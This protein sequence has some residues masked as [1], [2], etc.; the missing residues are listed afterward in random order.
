MYFLGVKKLKLAKFLNIKGVLLDQNQLQNYLEKVASEHILQAKSNKDTYPI[1]RLDENFKQITKTYDILNSH[2]K[3]GINIHPAGEWLLDNYYIIEETYKT[4]K[5]EL[6]LKKYTNFVGIQNGEYDGF[7]RIYVLA[8]E[9]VGYTDGRIDSDKLK[10]FLNAYQNKKTLGMEEIWNISVFLNISLIEKIRNVCDKVYFVQIQKY[11]VESIIERLVENKQDQDLVY[12]RNINSAKLPFSKEPFIEYLSYRLN[13]YG[14]KGL[15]YLKILEEQVEKTGTTISEIIKK[16]HFDIA[17]KKLSIGNCIK[18]IKDIQRINFTEIFEK[19]NGV[20]EILKKDPANVY[21]KMTYKTKEYYR[22]EIKELSK[23]IGISEIYITSKALELANKNKDDKKKKHIGYYIIDKGLRE[24]KKELDIKE[25]CLNYPKQKEKL[26]IGT[27]IGLTSIFTLLTTTIFINITQNLILYILFLMFSFI[28]ISEIVIKAI[29]YILSKNVKPK[30]IPK[31]D[32]TN[33][34]PKE[35]STMIIMP[36]ILKSKENVQEY[37]EKLEVYYLANK[38]EN[39]YFTLLGDCSTSSKEVEKYD[40]EVIEEGKQI[41]QKLNQKY[42]E[43]IFNF[44]YRKR[45]WNSKENNFL[46]WERKRG[47]ITEF[48]QFLLGKTENTF[49][50]NSL[51]NIELPNIKYIITLDSDTNLVLDTAKELIG[52]MAHILNTPVID[53]KRNIV[54]EGHALMQPRIGIDIDSS[55]KTLFTKIYA[56]MGGIDAYSGAISDIYQDNFG[57]GIFTGKGIYDLQVF[58]KV[59]ENAIPE[60]TVLSHD[61]LEGIYTRCGLVTD[62]ILLDG[63]PTKFNSYITR[64]SRWIRGDW[65][66]ISWLKNVITNKKQNKINNPIGEF[67]KFKILDNLRRSLLEITQLLS[68]IIILFTNDTNSISLYLIIFFSIFIDLVIELLNT[69]IFKKEGVKKQ[70]SFENKLPGL[71][72]SVVRSIINFSSIIYKAIISLK[73]ICI[74][75]YR[76]LKTKDHL[77]EWI[78]AD[79][80]EKISKEN[81]G[82]FFKE[83]WI[84]VLLGFVLFI[85][86]I[87]SFNI[88]MLAIS[89]L[90]MIAPVICC[91]ISKKIEKP[92]LY[93]TL[94]YGDQQ[95]ILDIAKNT[96]KYFEDYLNIENNFLPPDNYQ[97][98]RSNKAVDRTSSTNIGLGLMSIISAYDLKFIELDKALLLIQKMLETI[99]KLPKWNGHLY[100]WYNIKTLVPLRPEYISTVDSGNFIGYLIALK[101]FFME[102][103]DKEIKD[104]YLID[105]NL[106]YINKLINDTDFSKLYNNEISLFS[107]GFNIEENKLTDSYYDLLASEARQA[108][109][110]AIA[111]KDVPSKH[112]NSLSKTLTTIYGK[113]GLVSWSGTAFEYLMPNINIKKYSG[114]LLDESCKFMIMSQKKYCDKLQIPWGISEAAFNLKDLNSNY[115]YKAFG[116]P[117]LGL[118]RGLADDIV[119]SSYGSILAITEDPKEVIKNINILKKYNMYGKYGLYESIDFT[120]ERLGKGKKYEVVKTYMAHHQ[121]LILLSINNLVNNNILQERFHKNP[122]IKA[123]DILLQ[124]KLPED[125]IMTKERKEKIEKIKYVGNDTNY[126]KEIIDFKKDLP[127]LNI[128]SNEDYLVATNKNGTGFSKYKN[129]LI[130]RYKRTNE[131]NEGIFFYFKNIKNKQIW[132]NIYNANMQEYK[133]I[134]TADMNQ[135]IVTNDNIKTKIKTIIAPNDNVEIRNIKITNNGNSEEILEISSVLEPVLSTESGDYAHKAFNNLFLKYEEI[136]NGILIKRNKR[137]KEKEV[138]LAVGFFSDKGNIEKLEYE[139][140]KEKLYGRLNNNIPEK[141]ENSEKFSNN[142]G[143]VV[144]PI[145]AFRRT[146]KIAK[147]EKLELNLI[148]SISEKREEAIENLNNYKSFEHVKRT[149]EISKIRNEENARYLQVTGREMLVYQKILSYVIN[150]NPLRKLYINKFET[151]EL[152]QENLWSFGISGD[153]PLILVKIVEVNQTYVIRSLLKAFTFF[154]NKNITIDL[155]ILNEEKNVYERYVKDAIFREIANSNLSYLINKRIFVLNSNEIENKEVLNFKASLIVDADR[156]SLENTILE[157]EEEYLL[158][159]IK[160]EN[161]NIFKEET[162]F[163]KYSAEQLDLKYQNEYGGFSKDGK[164]YIICVD[165]NVPSVWS[166]VLAN[167][168]FGTIVTQNLGGFTWY[169]NSRL[170]RISKWSNDTLIDTPSEEIYVQD[171]SE[172]KVWKLGKGN[173]LTIHGFGYSKYEQNKLDIKQKL[174]IFVS[175]NKNIKFNLLQLKNNT[176]YTKKISLIYKVNTILDEDEIKS[177]GSINLEYNKLKDFIYSKNLYSSS[178]ESISYIYSSEKILSYTGNSESINMFSNQELNNENSLGNKPCMAIKIQV[179]LGAFE[180]KEISFILGACENKQ[181]ILTEFKEIENCK[182]EYQVTKNYWLNLLGKV[183]VKTPVEELNIILNGWTMY[184]TISSRLY[185]RS[186]FNQSGG[187]FGFRDQLQDSIST[188]FL[189][190]EMLKKQIL[191]HAEHQFIEG[192]TEHW[193][194]DETQRGIRTRFSDDRLWLVYVTIQYIEFTGD[195]NIL[196]IQIPYIE[197]KPLEEGKDEDYNIHLPSNM[198]ESLYNHCIRAINISLKFGENG[199]PLIGSGDWNDGFSTVG[200]KGKGESVWLGFFIYNILNDFI[201]IMKQKEENDNLVDEYTEILNKL[202]KALNKQG[203]DG[204]WYR[205]A[206]TDDGHVLGSSENEECRID[207]IAQSW[208]AI[209]NA[210]DNDKKYIAI[211]ALEK[212]LINKEIGII[213]LLDPPFENS[214]LEP[215]YIKAYLPGVREN[216]GQYTHAAIWAVIAFAKLKLEDKACQYFNMINPIEHSN[217]RKKADRYKIEPYVI[218]ADIYGSQNLLGRGGWTWYTGSSSWYYIAGIEYILGLKIKNQKL[219]LNPCVPKEWE[220]YFIHYKFEESIYNIKVK[221]MNKT[222]IVQKVVLNNQEIQEKEIKLIDNGKINEIEIF[223]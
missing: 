128:I 73:A 155:V 21:T 127:E 152:K 18:S 52:A 191:K 58:N 48:N 180:E 23:K 187:A 29:Q 101:T 77:L 197:G 135:T 209:S 156:G 218:P 167:E 169:K 219:S 30:L 210:G 85:F 34:I 60:N 69:I 62:V 65:Q 15:P 66:I 168:N 175:M 185:A 20:E 162:E 132:S 189:N 98:S 171:E 121:G 116:I 49:K 27:I 56:G 150:L 5:K 36:T 1:Q 67:G 157:L 3:L 86:S 186:G 143:L 215:G 106:E 104:K 165:K 107:I 42:G 28:P 53:E 196:D 19:I 134:F 123:V 160:K 181:E 120:P 131:Y 137:G 202:K 57:E 144:D 122:E 119:V 147:Q 55:R 43:N 10:S 75:L 37:L 216:G 124:E 12:K 148:I 188:K 149:F 140:D 170:N 205:R 204:R 179:E 59:L 153:F 133:T 201:P 24:L 93:K 172:N 90:W 22:N 220:E 45:L 126:F 173:L 16:E 108:S 46:G 206:Y 8:A 70:A 25:N 84:N 105:A 139:I 158:K 82:C 212:Y 78:T 163:E 193:W 198:Q 100:N 94:N 113:K 81:I 138:F 39:I 146:V 145:L 96:W 130:N 184:Q 92:D 95:E 41:I 112:W 211:E 176:N 50:Y 151:N 115:Q 54:V 141:I 31:L 174:E 74:T 80:A 207:S 76:V 109:L 72:L 142:L 89:I 61:L 79:E 192:D 6:T 159:Y 117:W 125:M 217:T 129:I 114:S 13:G 47:L 214:E 40:E 99:Y 102:I 183:S 136:E 17:L 26:Y 221:N 154:Q 110:V 199:L 68:L 64:L 11:K 195:Y 182:R 38:S 4:I 7:A 166:N 118:K 190:P 177:D 35:F 194:H 32:F 203:W 164:K 44:V 111:K 63:Y 83:M 213:K 14:K 97:E 103:E 87:F 223:L 71:K 33:G 2:L 161:K 222:N 178:I 9:I 200:N 88:C 91:I 51:L 208:A